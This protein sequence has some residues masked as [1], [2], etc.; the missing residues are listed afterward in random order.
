[1]NIK[2]D[3]RKKWFLDYYTKEYI[4]FGSVGGKDQDKLGIIPPN[5]YMD[6][7]LHNRDHFLFYKDEKNSVDYLYATPRLIVNALMTGS[8]DLPY[9]MLRLGMFKDT[10]LNW[11]HLQGVARFQNFKTAK[12]LLG[13]AERDLKQVKAHKEPEKK[14]KWAE[15]Y[16]GFVLEMMPHLEEVDL[17]EDLLT[18]VKTLRTEHIKHLPKF[19]NH[20]YFESLQDK[21]IGEFKLYE[22]L[23]FVSDVY[24]RSWTSS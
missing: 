14:L 8:S 13:V 6:S 22:G 16:L 3:A 1:M 5:V 24:F 7:S 2:V 11:L 12:M 18:K 10:S 20:V 23:K 15:T 19:M 9:K 21:V 17:G 4:D